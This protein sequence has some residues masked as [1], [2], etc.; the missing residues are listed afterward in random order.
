MNLNDRISKIIQYSKLSASEFADEIEVQRS[1]ISHIASGRNKPSL[2]FLI[3]IKEHFPAIQWDWL[4]LGQG[5]MLLE[6]KKVEPEILKPTSL[7]DL[8]SLIDDENF[9]ITESEDSVLKQKLSQEE[10]QLPNLNKINTGDSQRL[11]KSKIS[12]VN[13]VPENQEI[14]IKKIVFFYENGKFESFEQ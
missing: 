11:E 4:I 3:K 9:G 10:I 7:P 1:N 14:K 5:E 2:D 13:Q 12:E 6:E 8:F